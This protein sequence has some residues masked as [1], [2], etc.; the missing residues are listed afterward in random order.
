LRLLV[1]GGFG[2]IGGRLCEALSNDPRFEMRVLSRRN[3]KPL[4]E[5]A[6]SLPITQADVTQ[7]QSLVGVC[8]GI[9][10]VVHLAS[11]D[12][13][14]SMADP[15]RALNVNATGTYHLL[16][17][18]L[19]AG[20]KRFI[21]FST[22]R[23]YGD[24][25]T[26]KLYEELAPAPTHHYGIT[27]LAAEH[28][29]RQAAASGKMRGISVRLTNAV[30]APISP[31]VDRWNLVANDL[32]LQ[33]TTQGKI[34]LR[35][36]G[37][38]HRDFI[39]IS[40]VVDAVALLLS[41]PDNQVVYDLYNLGHGKSSSVRAL[42]ELIQ[43][44]AAEVLGELPVLEAPTP[45]DGE[46]EHPLRVDISRMTRLGYHPRGDLKSELRRTLEICREAFSTPASSQT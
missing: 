37:L 23:A 29:V 5:W 27:H 32:C 6:R 28:Y 1:T 42:A 16:E 33:A 34:T 43:E 41:V 19:R 3:P 11:L 30:G 35:S 17:E 24:R 15:V 39:P 13:V 40:D 36:P 38:Q 7:P 44:T 4:A 18:A 21:Y 9:D 26:G 20:V 10:G 12:E 46:V 8:H 14:E 22:L 2:Y 31:D 25:L 45:A